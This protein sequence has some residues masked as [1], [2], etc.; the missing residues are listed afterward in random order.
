MLDMRPEDLRGRLFDDVRA[1]DLVRC[2]FNGTDVHSGIKLNYGQIG[3][4]NAG[5]LNLCVPI[6]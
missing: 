2:D 5:T 3:G 6:L 4:L 1:S